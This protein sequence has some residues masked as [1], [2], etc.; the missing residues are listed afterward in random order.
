MNRSD[1]QL[2][3]GPSVPVTKRFVL[4]VSVAVA[5]AIGGLH[6]CSKRAE[7]PSVQPLKAKPAAANPSQQ[8]AKSAEDPRAAIANTYHQVRCMLVGKARPDDG[9]Y[10]R[11][12]F[13]D[14][15][16]FSIAFSKV[17]TEDPAWGRKAIA[18]SLAKPCKVTP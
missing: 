4:R 14:A 7:S 12:G 5:V 15:A 16:A 10:T 1:A 9:V 17:A 8:I 6:G 2:I 13:A 3:G 11:A 18:D